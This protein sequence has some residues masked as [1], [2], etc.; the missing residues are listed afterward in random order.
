M[1]GKKWLADGVFFNPCY[2]QNV[3]RRNVAVIYDNSCS[4]QS[5]EDG[6]SA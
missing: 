4:Q 3:K 5:F 2:I 6:L 1:C